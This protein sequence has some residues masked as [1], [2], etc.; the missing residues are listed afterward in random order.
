MAPPRLEAGLPFC[1]RADVTVPRP[2]CPFAPALR[3]EGRPCDR[4]GFWSSCRHVV[5]RRS[6]GPIRAR[7]IGHVP[8]GGGRAAAP[9]TGRGAR[10]LGVACA[11]LEALRPVP[12][13]SQR[14]GRGPAF[15]RF[16]GPQW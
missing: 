1:W 12:G 10:H 13:V 14:P 3:P 6:L 4:A 15:G 2:C 5:G 8:R 16:R 7:P 9:G 11:G